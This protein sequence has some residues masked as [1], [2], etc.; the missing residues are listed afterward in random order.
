MMLCVSLLTLSS[1]L[2]ACGSQSSTHPQV[3]LPTPTLTSS[4]TSTAETSDTQAARMVQQMSLDDKLGQLIVV[5]FYETTYT[6]AQQEMIKPFHPG[7]VILYGYSMGAAQQV[8]DLLAGGQRDSPIPM[9]TFLDL[10]GGYVDRL[11]KYLGPRISAPQM[12]ATGKPE[13]A[14]QQGETTA[15]DLLSFGFNTDLAPVVDVQIVNGPDLY[16]RTF[17]STPDTVV[18]YAGAWLQGLQKG[19]VIGTL[20]HFPGL[21]AA[22]TDA[23][24]DLP[25]INRTH[26]QIEATELAPYRAMI[27]NGQGE[28]QVNVVMSTDLLMPAFDSTYPAELSKPIITGVLRDELHYDGVAITD[29]LYMDGISSKWSFTQAAVLAIEAGNDMIMAP[30]RP[31]MVSSVINGLKDA[32]TK[33]D[34]T[35]AQVDTSVRRILALK[36]RFHLLVP[37]AVSGSTGTPT[38]SN[39]SAPSSPGADM[40]QRHYS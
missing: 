25:V 15:H 8:K 37:P 31:S 5:Q 13:V 27:A 16:G 23:H 39:V 9:F 36:I 7:G 28:T 29:A 4:P 6:P 35:Q 32:L 30:W 21:G 22:T 40:P 10:E 38:S 34:L 12:A 2:A 24:T 17:G 20:K 3:L 11:A 18:T 33:G 26:D 14:E 1:L 19:G